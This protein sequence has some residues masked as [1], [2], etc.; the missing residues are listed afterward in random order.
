MA[1]SKFMGKEA[2]A[3]DVRKGSGSWTSGSL[4]R[5]GRLGGGRGQPVIESEEARCSKVLKGSLK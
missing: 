5:W 3:A 1:G 2:T 4:G